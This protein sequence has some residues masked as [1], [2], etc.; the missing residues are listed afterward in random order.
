MIILIRVV[1]CTQSYA[2]LIRITSGWKPVGK[3]GAG[4]TVTE[5]VHDAVFPA[6]SVAVHVTVVDPIGKKD[7]EGGSQE[8]EDIPQLSV[9][10]GDG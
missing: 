2:V 8:T 10:V 1:T 3:G 6:R 9:A 7:P 4:K 5:N